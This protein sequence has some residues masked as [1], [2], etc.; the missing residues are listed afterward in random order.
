MSKIAITGAAGFI[1]SCLAHDLY[2]SGQEII[3][4]DDF[5]RADKEGNL[6]GLEQVTRVDRMEFVEGPGNFDLSGIYHLGA[7]T[8]TSEFDKSIFDLLN[9]NYSKTLWEFSAQAQIPF[10]YASSAATYGE[11]EH[12][13]DDDPTRIHRLKP[14]NPYGDSKQQFDL[15][16]ME[17]GD[18]PPLHVG[19]KFF[20]VYGPNEYHK[21]RMASVVFHTFN[22]IQK[23]GKMNLFQSHRPD[24]ENGEQKRDFIYV[25]DVVSLM[26]FWYSGKGGNGIFNVGSGQARSFND[27]ASA[28]FHALDLT[29]KIEYIPTPEDIRDKY[30]YYTKASMQRTRD[31]GYQDPFTTLED[32]VRDYVKHYLQSNTYF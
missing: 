28:V 2:R 6:K 18:K 3:L 27:L 24:F 30:Q 25:K 19:L 12:G 21:A 10:V 4:V 26:K 32:G 7:R 31:A 22:Q 5:S 13:F 15:W 16:T 29:P 1:G 9:F 8:D 17:Q 20:N 14:L 11:G 23:T